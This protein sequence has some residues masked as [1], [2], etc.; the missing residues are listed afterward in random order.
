M[1][2]Q[3]FREVAPTDD[4][5]GATGADGGHTASSGNPPTGGRSSSQ[6]DDDDEGVSEGETLH[7]AGGTDDDGVTEASARDT[8]VSRPTPSPGTQP[9][10]GRQ[11]E[12]AMSPA[13]HASDGTHS[14][15]LARFRDAVHAV[16]AARMWKTAVDPSTGYAYYYNEADGATSWT[17]PDPASNPDDEWECH[18]CTLH[19]PLSAPECDACGTLRPY[20]ETDVVD[21][22]TEGAGT[23]RT[24]G[25]QP[26]GSGGAGGD[27][28]GG[29]WMVEDGDHG[30]LANGMS[31]QL[32]GA[33]WDG[34]SEPPTPSDV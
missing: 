33:E 22:V 31:A 14:T 29:E 17:L 27:G 11:H 6:R 28:A 23:D 3:A 19:N 34:V 9:A 10:P 30:A 8:P 5:T 20:C 25:T 16:I 15:G 12:A 4:A 32:G 21:G 13:S 7:G 1:T 18:I 26:S 2:G 24:P